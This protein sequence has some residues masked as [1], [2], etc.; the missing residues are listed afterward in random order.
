MNFGGASTALSNP[1]DEVKPITADRLMA[2]VTGADPM[3][4]F[5]R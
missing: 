5:T 4:Q 3:G 1:V 2:W